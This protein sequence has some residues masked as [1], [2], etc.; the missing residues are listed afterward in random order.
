[1]DEFGNKDNLNQN[2]DF[3]GGANN[4]AA[5]TPSQTPYAQPNQQT[6]PQTQQNANWQ[7]QQQNFNNQP[8]GF[9]NQ[10]Q[11]FNNQQ[12]YAN[13]NFN[14]P[15]Y[16]NNGY[17]NF[18]QNQNPQHNPQYTNPNPYNN[19]NPNYNMYGQ[20]VN[21]PYSA[22]Q[23]PKMVYNPY[24]GRYEP[25][26]KQKTNTSTIVLISVIAVLL[27]AFITGIILFVVNNNK[28]S[29]DEIITDSSPFGE[30]IP[31]DGDDNSGDE[32]APYSD[33][34]DSYG[35]NQPQSYE[36]ETYEVEIE[37]QEDKG[38]SQEGENDK[39]AAE[40]DEKFK[41]LTEEK[42]PSDS[43]TG[44]YSSETAYNKVS[45]AVVAIQCFEDKISDEKTDI[46][47]EGTGTVVSADGYIITN[48]HVIGNSRQYA[49]KIVFNDQT[50]KEAKV[51]GFDSRTDIAVL[52]VDA[53]NLKYVTFGETASLKVGE[54]IIAIG[55]PGGT[56]F[57]NSLTKGIIS[58]VGRELSINDLV[59]Y[60]QI[61]ASINPGNSGG[62][63]CN[64]YGQV[65][66]INTA[67]VSSTEYEGMGFAIPS[68][69]V[70]KIA[71]DLIHYGYVKGRVRIGIAGTEIT[72]EEN[73]TYDIPMGV[74]IQEIPEGS[75]VEG[76]DI[77]VGDIITAVDGTEVSTFQN[78]YSILNE[79]KPGDKIK[80]TLAREKEN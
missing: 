56:T 67:K 45:P 29:S 4:T 21:N 22:P 47:A 78:V 72:E 36:Y 34:F 57:Q 12:Q 26:K 32:Y 46:I 73:Y 37:L 50:Y 61:D 60:I 8:Q 35:F 31:D 15:P 9:N 42:I 63:L 19:Q 30:M 25:E 24:T 48:S 14:R 53:T 58:F 64:I 28:K 17:S 1:M 76:T 79:H 80:L 41:S 3:N 70:V 44:D 39:E 62:P 71:N 16:Q 27:V 2:T 5:N 13:S 33:F 7:Y 18:Q 77:K 38:E 11:G 74:L 10:Q 55:N 54:D 43:K 75:P 51:V 69:T 68:D 65:I 40:P 23:T 66:G 52:K 49:L 6:T 59:D 20:P